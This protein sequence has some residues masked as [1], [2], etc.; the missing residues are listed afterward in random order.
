MAAHEHSEKMNIIDT[1]KGTKKEGD[2]GFR[3]MKAKWIS[4]KWM[5]CMNPLHYL[6]HNNDYDRDIIIHSSTRIFDS[7]PLIVRILS[8]FAHY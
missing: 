7:F 8:R 3:V 6:H 1:N 5:D 2:V 4:K